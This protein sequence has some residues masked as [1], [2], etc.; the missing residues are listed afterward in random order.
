M[1]SKQGEPPHG[2][3]DHFS[4]G[5]PTDESRSIAAVVEVRDIAVLGDRIA[6]LV[7]GAA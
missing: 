3:S 7:G 2:G 4:N 6:A 1:A 5:E